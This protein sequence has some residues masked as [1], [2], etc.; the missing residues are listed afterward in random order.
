MI[1]TSS[2]TLVSP[3]ILKIIIDDIIPAKEYEYLV[4]ILVFLAGVNIIRF[5]AGF[6]SD[7]LSILTKDITNIKI[8]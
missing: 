1:L 8:R 3:Y 5:L 7:Y 4:S 6:Y 2:G